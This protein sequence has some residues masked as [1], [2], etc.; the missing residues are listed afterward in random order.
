MRASHKVTVITCAPNHPSGI[1]YPGYANEWRQ[2]EEMGGVQVLRVKTFLS[3]N[4]GVVNRTLS[5]LSYMFSAA[6]FCRLV[7]NVDLVV[8]TSPQF[9]CG[10]SGCMVSRLLDCPW[11]VEIRDLWPES[12]HAVGAVRGRGLIGLLERIGVG[13]G[14]PIGI[15]ISLRNGVQGEMGIEH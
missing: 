10:L 15:L 1:V 4:K 8:S 6:A 9:F 7:K 14:T 5:Y 12:I 2:W 13:L 3:A 11:V